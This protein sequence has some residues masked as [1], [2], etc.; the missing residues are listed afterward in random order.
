[1][2]TCL[3]LS[4]ISMHIQR[5]RE[6]DP[7]QE[8]WKEKIVKDLT[9]DKA[10]DLLDS[11]DMRYHD[12]RSLLEDASADLVREKFKKWLASEDCKLEYKDLKAQSHGARY[13]FCKLV[14]EDVLESITGEVRDHPYYKFV[15]SWWEQ[16]NP[17]EPEDEADIEPYTDQEDVDDW[18]GV[19][20]VSFG[21]GFKGIS[22]YLW[23]HDMWYLMAHELEEIHGDEDAGWKNG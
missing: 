4:H 14:D 7:F 11:L 8:L 13:I 15:D 21:V 1:M 22:E 23:N 5:R 17:E 18:P 3:G 16:P 10:L 2:A 20:K 9:Y 6:V 12:D 19:A